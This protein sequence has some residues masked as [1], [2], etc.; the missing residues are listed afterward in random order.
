MYTV[1]E[2]PLLH[3]QRDGTRGMINWASTEKSLG[4]RATSSLG[5][6]AT[7]C[8][9]RPAWK[10]S[11]AFVP[12]F[13]EE[14]TDWCVGQ[15]CFIPLFPYVIYLCVCV[16]NEC[17]ESERRRERGGKSLVLDGG[18]TFFA[19]GDFVPVLTSGTHAQTDFQF[20]PWRCVVKMQYFKYL[21]SDCFC[22]VTSMTL[23]GLWC[24]LVF[25]QNDWTV[26]R[27]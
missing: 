9:V 23:C 27:S 17:K 6:R 22:R 13:S 26:K 4:I 24:S 3:E 2:L 14:V 21:T 15:G 25:L 20:V 1:R 11:L 10:T 5:T 19:G 16:R 8:L 12:Y 7:S 18:C